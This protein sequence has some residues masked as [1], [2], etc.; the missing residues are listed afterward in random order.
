MG[1]RVLCCWFGGCVV[2]LGVI[3]KREGMAHRT[4][5]LALYRNILR[6]H[7]RVLP[8]EMRILGDEYVP[9]EF[10]RH[11]TASATYVRSFLKEWHVYLRDLRKQAR[12][13]EFGKE[14][15]A[16][17]LVKLSPEQRQQLDLLK[18]ASSSSSSSS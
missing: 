8:Q 13:R 15:D 14:L 4:R 17:T 9:D 12:A 3:V 7:R 6:V 1:R 16:E 5:V 18:E 2:V 10:K 11:K